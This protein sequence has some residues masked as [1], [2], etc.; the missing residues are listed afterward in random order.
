MVLLSIVSARTESPLLNLVPFGFNDVLM[1]APTFPQWYCNISG[2]QYACPRVILQ[3]G[4]SSPPPGWNDTAY[5][6][7][8]NPTRFTSLPTIQSPHNIVEQLHDSVAPFSAYLEGSNVNKTFMGLTRPI[9]VIVHVD[10]EARI[11]NST[12]VAFLPDAFV[13]NASSPLPGSSVQLNEPLEMCRAIVW[14]TNET[15]T[16]NESFLKQAA[17]PTQWLQEMEHANF[18][19]TVYVYWS[20]VLNNTLVEDD[21]SRDEL[22]SV[23]APGLRSVQSRIWIFRDSWDDCGQQFLNITRTPPT[24][25]RSRLAR[26]RRNTRAVY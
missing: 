1:S 17:Y 4:S 12:A 7:L 21:T 15:I 24:S 9:G 14:Y 26:N 10:S 11:V 2:I 25:T 3:A 19:T 13:G 6:D 16:D 20:F 18:S 5:F 22:E 23:S 8:Y